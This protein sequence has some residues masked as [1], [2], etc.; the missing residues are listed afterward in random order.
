[1]FGIGLAHGRGMA[2]GRL[3]ST[4]DRESC[5]CAPDVRA[6]PGPGTYA[7]HTVEIHRRTNYDRFHRSTRTRLR[8]SPPFAFC[9]TRRTA[10]VGTHV[11]AGIYVVE[12]VWTGR[13]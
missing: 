11:C 7:R 4:A 8:G 3:V 1:M 13:D 6:S 10:L 9:V 5:G 12:R 2:R